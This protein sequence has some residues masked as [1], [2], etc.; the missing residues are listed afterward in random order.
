MLLRLRGLRRQDRTEGTLGQSSGSGDTFFMYEI[1]VA[2][3]VPVEPRLP[4][5][6]PDAPAP[7]VVATESDAAIAH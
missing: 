2:D 4:E 3:H 5:T 6:D 7:R 1:A